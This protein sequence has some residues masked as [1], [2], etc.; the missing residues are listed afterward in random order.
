MCGGGG[1]GQGISLNIHF[2]LKNVIF[3]ILIENRNFSTSRYFGKYAFV[4][5]RNM[6]Q[7]LT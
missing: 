1:S 6:G 7:K 3:E 4:H 2:S 5:N